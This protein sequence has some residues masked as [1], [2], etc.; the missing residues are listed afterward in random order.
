VTDDRTAHQLRNVNGRAK[1]LNRSGEVAPDM[2]TMEIVVCDQCG[3]RF[4]I[5]HRYD[6][7]DA[8]LASR[9]ATWLLQQFTWDHIREVK[10][11]QSIPLPAA[12]DIEDA[13]HTQSKERHA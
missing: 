12:C 10:H 5:G 13:H 7:Q 9:Q 8:T 1:R 4:G 11:H 3:S 6:A 2:M